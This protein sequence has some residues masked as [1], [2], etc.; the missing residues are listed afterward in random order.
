MSAVRERPPVM[1]HGQTTSFHVGEAKGY[2]TVNLSE[3]GRPIEIFLKLAKQG[4]TLSGI[5]DSL[6]IL[7][8]HSL[9]RGVGVEEIC[10]S[11]IGL[12]FEPWGQTNDPDIPEARSISDYIGRRLALDYVDWEVASELL[13]KHQ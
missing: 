4:S 3:D 1:R 11:L 13:Q 9:Q 2:M 12:R 5:F 6:A 10:D 8:S 7:I